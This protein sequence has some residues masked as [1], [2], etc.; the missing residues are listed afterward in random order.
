[1]FINVKVITNAA[2][3]EIIK[4]TKNDLI[5][6]LTTAPEKGKANRKLLQLLSD[7]FDIPKL[8]IHIVKGKY[9]AK[10]IINITPKQS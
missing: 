5:I 10:K 9:N 8:N 2:K 6:K 7:Y 1:M 4:K 3:N